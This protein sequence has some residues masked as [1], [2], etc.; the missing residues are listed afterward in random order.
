MMLSVNLVMARMGLLGLYIRSMTI[1]RVLGYFRVLGSTGVDV[2]SLTPKILDRF[3]TQ[4][5]ASI[6]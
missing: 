5:I 3:K 4:L 6:P 1:F 2:E